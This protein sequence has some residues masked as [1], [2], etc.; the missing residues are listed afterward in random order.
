MNFSWIALVWTS[1]LLNIVIITFPVYTDT[2]PKADSDFD[3]S[4]VWLVER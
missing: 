3:A 4:I 2:A 1:I